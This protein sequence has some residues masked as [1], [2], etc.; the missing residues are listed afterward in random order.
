MYWSSMLKVL[1]RQSEPYV[2]ISWGSG[3]ED[4]LSHA[5]ESPSTTKGVIFVD[6]SPDGIEWMVAAR[7]HCW[8]E[9]QMLEYRQQD[10][11]S[12]ISLSRIILALGIPW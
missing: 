6:T 4:V 5:L 3:G 9:A 8:D 2:S 7:E 10:L 1:G 11:T 12:R